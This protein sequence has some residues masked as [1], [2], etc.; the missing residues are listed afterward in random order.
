MKKILILISF[1]ILAAYFIWSY[2]AWFKSDHFK[3]FFFD[4]GQGDSA[5]IVTPGGKAILID[6]GPD[7]KVLRGLGTALP[8][9]RHRIDLMVITHAH[10]DHITGLI[11]VSRRYRIDNILKNNLD[12][13]TPTLNS[14]VKVFNKN[15]IKEINA[16]PGTFFKFD[17][18]CSLSILA[19]T[20]DKQVNDND[21]SIVTMFSCLGRR[22]L[23]GGDAGVLIENKLLNQG[24]DLRAD[25]FKVSHHGSLSAN[26]LKY[27]EGIKPRVAV[28]SVGINNKFGHPSPLILDRLKSLPVD[29]YRTDVFGTMEFLANYKSIIINR[30]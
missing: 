15:S 27:L 3:I 25:I 20:K 4:V 29:I 28:V 18:D 13:N 30:P 16:E 7:T 22:V 24:I 10:D 5:L 19:A 26:S 12:F 14:L 6:G 23:L 11:E 17:N 9:W 2:Q 21:Y 1:I 8:F